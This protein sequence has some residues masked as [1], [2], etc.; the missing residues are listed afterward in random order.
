MLNQSISLILPVYNEAAIVEETVHAFLAGLAVLT[1][2]FEVIVVDDGSDDATG[3]ILG[4]MAADDA[5]VRVLCN[6]KNIGS[7]QSLWRGMQA[8]TKELVL[9]NFAD[10]PF[11]LADGEAVL[12]PLNDGVTDFVVVARQDRHANSL[13][14]KL[15]SLTNYVLIRLLFGVPIMDFQFVQAYRRDILTGIALDSTGTFVPPEL[16]IRLIDKGYSYQ[17]VICPFHRRTGGYAKCGRASVILTTVREILQFWFKRGPLRR[18]QRPA[19]R[20]F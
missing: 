17:Q 20:G 2:D 12:E 7:G 10:R 1:A 16:M 8:A 6:L 18:W 13:Y 5:R 11:D 3:A 9:T 14:R 19:R 15:T 4:R